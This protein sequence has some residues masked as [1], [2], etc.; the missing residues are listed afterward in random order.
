MGLVTEMDLAGIP[1]A[2][3]V[4]SSPIGPE[5]DFVYL[6]DKSTEPQEIRQPVVGMLRRFTQTSSAKSNLA[7]LPVVPT[8]ERS[9]A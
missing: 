8:P 7:Q 2:E 6:L 5:F 9:P 3:Q 4:E 1:T